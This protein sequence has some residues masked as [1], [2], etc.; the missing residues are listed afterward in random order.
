MD[1]V[2]AIVLTLLPFALVLAVFALL[3][4]RLW[5][6]REQDGRRPP[7]T[8][9]LAKRMSP[10]IVLAL[11]IG[12]GNAVTGDW[13]QAASGLGGACLFGIGIY[14]H[15]RRLKREKLGALAQ[16][17]HLGRSG[18]LVV[19]QPHEAT[20]GPARGRSDDGVP[21]GVGDGVPPVRHTGAAPRTTTPADH[22]GPPALQEEMSHGYRP[23]G[24]STTGHDDWTEVRPASSHVE[25][26]GIEPASSSVEPGLLRV[27]SAMSFSRPRGS[28]GHVPDRLSH[29]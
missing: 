13:P 3:W 9:A 24:R 2:P 17:P 11:A 14:L 18:C 8:G 7:T 12:L 27:Q 15:A 10:F 23:C 16:S 26:A 25:L 19:Q 29:G 22:E 6:M 28:H 1:T 5:R 21:A 20:P 4:R